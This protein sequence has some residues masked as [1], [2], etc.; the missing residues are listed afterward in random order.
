[1]KKLLTIGLLVATTLALALTSC[2]NNVDYPGNWTKDVELE[3]GEWTVMSVGKLTVSGLTAT[4]ELQPSALSADNQV[5]EGYYIA[6]PVPLTKE[7]NY[8]GCKVDVTSNC[9][10][11]FGIVFNYTSNPAGTY[12]YYRLQVNA[13]GYY[14]IEKVTDEGKTPVKDWDKNDAICRA[15]QTNKIVIYTEK[16]DI[17]IQF[18]GTEIHRIKNAELKSGGYGISCNLGHEDIVKDEKINSEF[19]FKEFQ[20]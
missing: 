4:Y 9:Q 5:E 7:K 14:R 17:A 15:P 6:I 2:K 20:Y 18:N 3:Q 11:G 12:S 1:M 16:N 13:N 8:T 19:K 10:G